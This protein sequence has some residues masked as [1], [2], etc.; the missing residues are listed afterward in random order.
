MKH[1]EHKERA[2]TLATE[3]VREERSNTRMSDQEFAY[4]LL[5]RLQANHLAYFPDLPGFEDMRSIE[6]D[7]K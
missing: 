7:G 4:A 6:E 3:F 2:V 1:D 5:S